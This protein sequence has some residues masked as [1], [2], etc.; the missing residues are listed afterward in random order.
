MKFKNKLM[1][2]ILHSPCEKSVTQKLSSKSGGS[3][4]SSW[5]ALIGL[6]FIDPVTTL[7]ALDRIESSFLNPA[8]LPPSSQNVP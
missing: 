2:L 5:R 7:R 1:I 6:D 4:H 3:P 8:T